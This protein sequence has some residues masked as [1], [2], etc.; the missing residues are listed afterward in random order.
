MAIS[1]KNLAN[2]NEKRYYPLRNV[3]NPQKVSL[4]EITETQYRAIYPEIWATRKREQYHHRCMCP[5]KYLWKCDGNCDLCE[6]HAAGDILSLDAPVADGN[7]NMYDVIS[8]TAP[9]MED[10]IADAI[11]LEQLIARFRELDPEADRIIE[12]FGDELSD[13]KIAEQ[14][15]RKQRTF[16][17]QMKKIRIELR[18]VCG[19]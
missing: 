16:A 10:V 7:A 19:Y 13:R 2:Q 5:T 9:T 6:Y 3:E 11:L 17:D 14:L 4:V 1:D 8:N 18:K 12:L 15:G